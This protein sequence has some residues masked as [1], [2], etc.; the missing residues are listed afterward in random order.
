MVE[1]GGAPA[2]AGDGSGTDPAP[3]AT[4][5]D[6]KNWME[7]VPAEFRSDPVWKSYE[8]KDATEVFK[9]HAN[10]SKLIGGDK[11]V[12]P[13]GKLDTDANWDQVFDKLGRPK[14]PKEYKLEMPQG[15]VPDGT[16]LDPV[17]DDEFKTICHKAGILPKQAQSIYGWFAQRAGEMLSKARTDDDQA[18]EN[19]QDE[20]KRELGT[21]EKFEQFISLSN[22]VVSLYSGSQ[23]AAARVIDRHGNDPDIVR[24]LGNIGKAM[25]EDAL[26]TGGKRFADQADPRQKLADIQSNK[27]NPM[28]EA[29][30][31]KEHPQHQYAVDEVFRLTQL[32]HGNKPI[33]A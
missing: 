3:A 2:G 23:E 28:Y 4:K 26:V 19:A 22:K 7:F 21:K 9:A 27:A 5:L 6:G 8:G 33:Q 32:V 15:A 12:V 17:L 11:I 18:Y 16:T 13:A 1:A 24:L 14:D 25:D 31:K 10:Q 20:L 30:W 29:Y